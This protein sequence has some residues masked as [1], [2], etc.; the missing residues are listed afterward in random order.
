MSVERS[1][2]PIHPTEVVIHRK[3]TPFLSDVKTKKQKRRDGGLTSRSASSHSNRFLLRQPKTNRVVQGH[4]IAVRDSSVG[5]ARP[6]FIED[7]SILD[8]PFG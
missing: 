7:S 6:H 8:K 2:S 5:K 3:V 4:A 1:H